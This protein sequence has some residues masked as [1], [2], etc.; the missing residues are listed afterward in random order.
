MPELSPTVRRLAV[1][2]ATAAIVALNR[3][4]GL[5]LEQ[6]DVL[7]LSGLAV[8]YLAQSGYVAAAKARG[9]ADTAN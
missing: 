4:L 9:E 7:A 2:L 6:P 8:A 1:T 3:K 5:G